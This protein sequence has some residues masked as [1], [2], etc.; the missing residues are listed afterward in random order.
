MYLVILLGR[1]DR[2]HA[3]IRSIEAHKQIMQLKSKLPQENDDT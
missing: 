2:H 3:Q 1:R